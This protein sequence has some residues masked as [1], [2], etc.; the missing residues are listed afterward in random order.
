MSDTELLH[1]LKPEPVRRLEDVY[2]GWPA[3]YMDCGSE[4]ALELSNLVS[5]YV[6]ILHLKNPRLRPFAFWAELDF[7]YYR[8]ERVRANVI[9]GLASSSAL[10]AFTACCRT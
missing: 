9:C 4:G 5:F 6:L 7:S 8:C 1:K 2:R 10:V 3:A